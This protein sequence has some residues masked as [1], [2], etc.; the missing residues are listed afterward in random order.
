MARERGICATIEIHRYVE[1][2]K[3]KLIRGMLGV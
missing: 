3:A 1:D 2:F